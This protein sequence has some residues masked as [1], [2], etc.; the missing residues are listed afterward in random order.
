[1][2]PYVGYDSA[3]FPFLFKGEVPE[4]IKPLERVVVVDDFAL[5]LPYVQSRG[6]VIQTIII[7]HGNQGKPLPLIVL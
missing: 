5:S 7:S 3:S 2:N 4:G 6:T 1:M